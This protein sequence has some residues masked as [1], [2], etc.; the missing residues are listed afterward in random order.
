[1]T[2]LAP[3]EGAPTGRSTVVVARKK[4]VMTTTA[5][6]ERDKAQREEI[7]LR[8]ERNDSHRAAMA[9]PTSLEGL[10]RLAA[11]RYGNLV[12]AWS[13][14]FDRDGNGRIS[15]FEFSSACR[16]LGFEGNIKKTFEEMD[17]DRNGAISM[18]NFDPAMSQALSSFKELLAQKYGSIIQAFAALDQESGALTP[19]RFALKCTA[20]GY[21]GNARTLFDWLDANDSGTVTLDE[22][23]PR[24]AMAQARDEAAVELLMGG[25]HMRT[26][27]KRS[28]LSGQY[29]TAVTATKLVKEQARQRYKADIEARNARAEH[30]NK[31]M[32]TLPGFKSLLI[33]R[34]GSIVNA[35]KCGLDK[36]GNGR[37]NFNDF[38]QGCRE[39]GYYAPRQLWL[40]LD[41]ENSGF[42][43]VYEIDPHMASL[44]EE[45]AQ[46]ISLQCGNLEAAWSH[47]FDACRQQRCTWPSFLLSCDALGYHKAKAK[48]VFKALGAHKGNRF[49]LRGDFDFLS[50]WFVGGAGDMRPNIPVVDPMSTAASYAKQRRNALTTSQRSIGFG[51]EPVAEFRAFL[52]RRFGT[53][54]AAW[55]LCLDRDR[56]GT[57]SQ[58]EFCRGMREMGY[59]GNARD[60]FKRLDSDGSGIVSLAEMDPEIGRAL[61]VFRQCCNTYGG[62]ELIWDKFGLNRAGKNNMDITQFVL[63][64]QM[65]RYRLSAK[66][67]FL[68]LDIDHSGS[69]SF[70]EI[71]WAAKP[72]VDHKEPLGETLGAIQ[73]S[74]IYKKPTA[75]SLTREQVKM[76]ERKLCTVPREVV[77]QTCGDQ[78]A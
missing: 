70:N 5:S 52:K 28:N 10:K 8:K 14:A 48:Q 47:L 29:D 76:R 16:A 43:S 64:C 17:V 55:L 11:R 68:Q 7:L 72:T 74:G 59:I 60:I 18:E 62:L 19:D 78:V 57:L 21:E 54:L 13:I 67:L 3:T 41:A 25:H 49:I 22:I 9:A 23:D 71:L 51:D 15:F 32:K 38:C 45:L 27:T 2:E 24:A 1:M 75:S 50:L 66:Q 34:Y 33:H 69:L 56:N 61:T 58:M 20:I 26:D 37:L 12:K 73:L 4:M 35:W 46:R 42:I 65:M 6:I 53:V 77:A 39:I 31:A 36:D 44:M 63:A 40:E 30:L